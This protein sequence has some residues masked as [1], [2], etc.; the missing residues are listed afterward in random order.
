MQVKRTSRRPKTPPTTFSRKV[1]LT[2]TFAA[3]CSADSDPLNLTEL[4][5]MHPAPHLPCRTRPTEFLGLLYFIVFKRHIRR[6]A[7]VQRDCMQ[8]ASSHHSADCGASV[9][10][11]VA[12][13]LCPQGTDDM[14]ECKLLTWCC[15]LCS[16]IKVSM[17]LLPHN[18]PPNMLPVSGTEIHPLF[19]FM[20]C[21]YRISPRSGGWY[22][23]T[24][25]LFL[26]LPV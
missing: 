3:P 22:V 17:A 21:V 24:K 25:P 26:T 5:L 11:A 7:H 6:V 12:S 13:I 23:R 8:A 10:E 2:P 16:L 4:R 9:R 20:L 18:L 14:D 19:V 15:L 1:N